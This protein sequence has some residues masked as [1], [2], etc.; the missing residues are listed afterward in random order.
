MEWCAATF[1]KLLTNYTNVVIQWDVT[2][3]PSSK[4]D[5]HSLL[6]VLTQTND[7]TTHLYVYDPSPLRDPTSG[8]VG[9]IMREWKLLLDNGNIEGKIEVCK[10]GLQDLLEVRN[11]IA[12]SKTGSWATG[13]C[14]SVCYLMLFVMLRFLWFD[15]NLVSALVQKAFETE[16]SE[17]IWGHDLIYKGQNLKAKQDLKRAKLSACGQYLVQIVYGAI[18]THNQDTLLRRLAVQ[19]YHQG[20]CRVRLDGCACPKTRGTDSI[21]CDDHFSLLKSRLVWDRRHCRVESGA[22]WPAWDN[23]ECQFIQSPRVQSQPTFINVDAITAPPYLL[24]DEV[25]VVILTE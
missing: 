8:F 20:A 17:K 15:L 3:S 23:A 4:Q 16:I 13:L 1:L 11:R 21:M 5:G 10:Q 12:K 14:T 25:D 9:V 18:C 2:Y 7:R 22:R 24:P 6:C 19:G